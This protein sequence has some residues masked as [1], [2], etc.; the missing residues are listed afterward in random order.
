[1]QIIHALAFAADLAMW[2]V[3]ARDD[4]IDGATTHDG[5]PAWHV[6]HPWTVAADCNVIAGYP[7]MVLRVC[8]PDTLP[9]KGQLLQIFD[10]TNQRTT[11]YEC[12]TTYLNRGPTCE[13]EDSGR[14]CPI[15]IK[16]VTKDVVLARN[17][18][19]AYHWI[20]FLFVIPRLV[21]CHTGILEDDLRLTHEVDFLVSEVICYVDDLNDTPDAG[22]P[23]HEKTATDLADVMHG[24][25]QNHLLYATLEVA[26]ELATASSNEQ[27]QRAEE[28]W[29][30]LQRNYGPGNA[31]D[32]PKVVALYRKHNIGARVK[33]MLKDTIYTL[34]KTRTEA[35]ARFNILAD[36]LWNLATLVVTATPFQSVVRDLKSNADLNIAEKERKLLET[37]YKYC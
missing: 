14:Q 9:T 16:R 5:R 1:M 18:L 17:Y 7:K 32:A 27:Q 13:A 3:L 36:I 20:L 29:D 22:Q 26:Q 15:D 24:D 34:E 4:M 30:I 10:D 28:I 31:G 23:L 25:V 37:I 33:A 12:F 11:Y 35:I 6:L 8:V 19:R 21:L 2:P